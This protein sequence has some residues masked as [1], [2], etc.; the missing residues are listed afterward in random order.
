MECY[1]SIIHISDNRFRLT[2]ELMM[3]LRENGFTDLADKA[4]ARARRWMASGYDGSPVDLPE[5]R[6]VIRCVEDE[7]EWPTIAACARER[8]LN[9]SQLTK[10]LRGEVG[11]R[12]VKGNRYER[13]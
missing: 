11:Y 5:P 2:D 3:M 12:T 13:I 1:V 8:Q 9:Y 4:A 10:H 7:T 6:S